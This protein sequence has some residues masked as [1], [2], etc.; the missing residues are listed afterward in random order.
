MVTSSL[1]PILVMSDVDVAMGA[2]TLAVGGTYSTRYM[3]WVRPPTRVNPGRHYPDWLLGY[4]YYAPWTLAQSAW[5]AWFHTKF[6]LCLPL[7]FWGGLPARFFFAT[8][9]N[10]IL[11]LW[12]INNLDDL[13]PLHRRVQPNIFL[14]IAPIPKPCPSAMTYAHPCPP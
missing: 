8:K 4:P 11:M 10:F 1:G 12:N 7:L 5:L 9:I 6:G 14:Q 13:W 3:P 2:A